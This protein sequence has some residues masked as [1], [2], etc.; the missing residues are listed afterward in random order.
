MKCHTVT[1]IYFRHKF[2]FRALLRIYTLLLFNII[3]F[4]NSFLYGFQCLLHVFKSVFLF[5]ENIFHGSFFSYFSFYNSLLLARNSIPILITLYWRNWKSFE[6]IKC[7]LNSI[8][9]QNKRWF[10]EIGKFLICNKI[11]WIN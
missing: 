3:N 10:I 7:S 9:W 8:R 5:P 2:K 1:S 6:Y 11:F 4:L